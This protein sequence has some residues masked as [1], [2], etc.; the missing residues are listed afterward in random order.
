[1][2]EGA[3]V[4]VEGRRGRWQVVEPAPSRNGPVWWC[5]PIRSGQPTH[6]FGWS[7][8]P[9]DKMRKAKVKDAGR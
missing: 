7:A 3:I 2:T 9:E 5:L 6:H 8:F 1:M 4:H